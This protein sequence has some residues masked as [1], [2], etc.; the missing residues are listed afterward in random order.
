MNFISR[1]LKFIATACVAAVIGITAAN[2]FG[3]VSVAKD[4]E[5]KRDRRI[6][7]RNNWPHVARVSFNEF[8]E[9]PLVSTDT[10]E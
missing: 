8:L 1:N 2:A 5:Y 9:E 7:S 6:C 10:T 4:K 3:Q